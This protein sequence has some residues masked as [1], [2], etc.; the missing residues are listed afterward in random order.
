M[1]VSN[2]YGRVADRFRELNPS[3]VHEIPLSMEMEV[4]GYQ[5]KSFMRMDALNPFPLRLHDFKT[6]S[7]KYGMVS[8]WEYYYSV[9]WRMYLIACDDVDDFQYDIFHFLFEPDGKPM[10]YYNFLFSREIDMENIVGDLMMGFISFCEDNHLIDYITLK[11]KNKTEL[12]T[13]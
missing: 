12:I 5:V 10:A 9:Q 7:K 8:E 11:E 2:Y 4:S 1:V 6:T 13:N 3:L